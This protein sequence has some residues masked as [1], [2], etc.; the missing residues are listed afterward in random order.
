MG[1]GEGCQHALFCSTHSVGHSGG[2]GT[3]LED[4]QTSVSA[5]GAGLAPPKTCRLDISHAWNFKT[6]TKSLAR[7]FITCA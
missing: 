3:F 6:W 4:G 2:V 1:S 7:H 5:I